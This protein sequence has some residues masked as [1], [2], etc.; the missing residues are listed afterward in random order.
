MAAA[1]PSEASVLAAWRAAFERCSR[2]GLSFAV[3]CALGLEADAV[4]ATMQTS[5]RACRQRSTQP[6]DPAVYTC[7]YLAGMPIVL[8]TLDESQMGQNSAATT[9]THLLNTFPDTRHLLLCGIAGALILPGEQLDG[10][11]DL[12]LGD[13]VYSKIDSKGASA[14]SQVDFGKEHPSGFVS[15]DSVSYRC[16]R[17]VANIVRDLEREANSS[18]SSLGHTLQLTVGDIIAAL[19]ESLQRKFAAPDP[20]TDVLYPEDYEHAPE[21][22]DRSCEQAHC[23]LVRQVVRAPREPIGLPRVFGGH[24]TSS[25]AVV[26]SAKARRALIEKT[27][28]LCCEM[29]TAAI[30]FVASCSTLDWFGFRGLCDY[31]DSHKHKLWQPRAAIMA[32]AFLRMILKAF[33]DCTPE[34]LVPPAASTSAAAA[35]SSGGG[36]DGSAAAAAA[37]RSAQAGNAAS[38]S[39]RARRDR[40]PEQSI[41]ISDAEH[42]ANAAADA[43][44]VWRDH[45]S[46]ASVAQRWPAWDAKCNGVVFIYDT[47][48]YTANTLAG[49]AARQVG[50]EWHEAPGS[51]QQVVFRTEPVLKLLQRWGMAENFLVRTANTDLGYITLGILGQH[52]ETSQLKQLRKHNVPSDGKI[53]ARQALRDAGYA[54]Q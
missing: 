29:E 22:E 25:N 23:E 45:A 51:G 8:V 40:S 10:P 46:P 13:V 42:A 36:G 47:R 11:R 33:V 5:P 38:G 20:R 44:E 31:A 48:D 50:T 32:A 4:T 37:A 39:K 17:K 21:M 12:R 16:S 24:I 28:G 3:V 27:G 15:S 43:D 18:A 6:H 7:G 41:A 52:F 35:A 26:K 53:A 14:Y 34:L 9:A 1:L 19:P 54:L 30:A 2:S 49:R